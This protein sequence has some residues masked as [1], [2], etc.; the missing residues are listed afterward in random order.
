MPAKVAISAMTLT[1]LKELA[2]MTNRTP[3]AVLD[4]AVDAQYRR[5]KLE[6]WN[7]EY[8]QLR[9]NPQAWAHTLKER[10]IWDQTNLDGIEIDDA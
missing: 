6:A 7:R 3:S 10:R 2:T 5:F 9:R 4:E 1:K 8:A